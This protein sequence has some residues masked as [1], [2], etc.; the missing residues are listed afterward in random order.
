MNITILRAYGYDYTTD[1]MVMINDRMEG[2]G[3]SWVH[4]QG[5]RRGIGLIGMVFFFGW[6]CFR[7]VI[8]S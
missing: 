5:A 2:D 6:R 3:I 7:I 8:S 4:R 1:M